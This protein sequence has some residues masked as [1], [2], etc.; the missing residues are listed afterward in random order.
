MKARTLFQDVPIL[1]KLFVEVIS[2]QTL[3]A[4]INLC[5]ITRLKHE[6]TDD[7]QRAAYTGQLYALVNGLSAFFQFVFLPFVLQ[8]VSLVWILRV[9]PVLPI[10]CIFATCCQREPTLAI[11]AFTLLSTKTMVRITFTLTSNFNFLF[12]S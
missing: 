8:K 9:M 4:I 2:F 11:I 1:G 3:M 10:I 5:F 12:S 7:S 6:I